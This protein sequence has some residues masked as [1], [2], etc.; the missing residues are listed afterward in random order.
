MC[1]RMCVLC[2]CM[3]VMVC[4]CVRV[5]V[6]VCVCVS[7]CVCV[8]VCVY[9]CYGVCVCERNEANDMGCTEKVD[10]DCRNI[11]HLISYIP[12]CIYNTTSWYT[13]P[14]CAPLLFFPG[15]SCHSVIQLAPHSSP[16][17]DHCRYTQRGGSG[18]HLGITLVVGKDFY[19]FLE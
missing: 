15:T 3:C 12:Q 2:V 14:T 10:N 4:A 18:I 5:I 8:C 16:P 17:L 11:F 19:Q 9:V 1:I 6:C 7:W 13:S